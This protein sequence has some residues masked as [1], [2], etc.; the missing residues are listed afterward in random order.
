[1][2]AN[3]PGVTASGHGR[4]AIH[5]E[6]CPRGVESVVIHFETNHYRRVDPLERWRGHGY[7]RWEVGSSC[8]VAAGLIGLGG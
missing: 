1:M 7:T 3:R 8:Q 4:L 6:E 5:G 2:I